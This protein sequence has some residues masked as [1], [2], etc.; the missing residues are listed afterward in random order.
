[1][2]IREERHIEEYVRHPEVMAERERLRI[3]QLLEEDPGAALYATFLR[4][5]YDQLEEE[6]ERPP[7]PRV[8]EFVDRLFGTGAPGGGGEEDM[9]ST[10]PVEPHDPGPQVRPTVLAA[11]APATT[12]DKRDSPQDDSSEE[13]RFVLLASLASE[14][15]KVL[16]RVLGDRKIGQGRLYVLSGLNEKSW[17]PEPHAVV[18]FPELGHDILTGEDGRAFFEL[19]PESGGAPVAQ[20]QL[21]QWS[22]T[23]AVVHRPVAAEELSPGEET[24]LSLPLT[25]GPERRPDG[26]ERRL[27]CRRKGR[28]LAVTI[29][30][31]AAPTF[32]A[33]SPSEEEPMLLSLRA[34][35]LAPKD[36]SSKGPITL[37]LY[38]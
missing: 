33:V 30:G 37:R 1:M 2:N 12:S 5:F 38:K 17:G 25:D 23:H 7:D 24:I 18:S 4:D 19:H 13:K 26:P 21:E 10:V 31:E 34:G 14:E 22:G 3:G 11:D 36:V 27:L 32:L 28:H 29:E 9:A 20:G 8:E 35:D 6:Q 15:E 16:V